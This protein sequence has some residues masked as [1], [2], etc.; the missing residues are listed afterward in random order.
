MLFLFFPLI[1]KIDNFLNIIKIIKRK[2]VRKFSFLIKMQD[3]L[4]RFM[5]MRK[6]PSILISLIN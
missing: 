1:P 5:V 2:I 4:M 6:N 3:F